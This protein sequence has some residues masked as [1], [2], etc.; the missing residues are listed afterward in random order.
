ML[1]HSNY[2]SLS[3][4]AVKLLLDLFAQYNGNN[5][6]DFQMTWGFMSKDGRWKSKD[7]LYKARDELVEKGFIEMTRQGGKHRCSLYAV[8]WKEINYCKGKLDV[9][10]TLVASGAWK[11]LRNEK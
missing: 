5:N 2:A 6:G 1:R 8:T 7:T 10:D 9:A 11:T 4:K 3:P